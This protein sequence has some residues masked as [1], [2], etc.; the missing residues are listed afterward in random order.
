MSKRA[1]AN[2]TK[3][4]LGRRDAVLYTLAAVLLIVVG[5]VL[6]ARR[7]S[8]NV[9]PEPR[10]NAEHMHT[11]SPD[12]YGA[13][14]EAKEVYRMAAHVKST[15]DGIFCYCYCK[16]GG[17]YSLL[18]CFK[19]DHGAGCDVCL[20][21]ARLAYDMVQKGASLAQVRAAIDAQFGEKS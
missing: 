4:R 19:D 1:K 3:Q 6:F 9:H 11:E 7:A 8:A 18:D 21:E 2:A 17:H 20:A 16:G 15:L 12:R 14:P 10:A 13:Y 5:M